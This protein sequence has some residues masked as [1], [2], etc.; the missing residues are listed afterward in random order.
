MPGRRRDS[1]D[2]DLNRRVKRYSSA[3]SQQL[4][5]GRKDVVL[6][7]TP[8]VETKTDG[9]NVQVMLTKSG[10]GTT[11]SLTRERRKVKA[12]FDETWSVHESSQVTCSCRVEL[13]LDSLQFT[14]PLASTY[15]SASSS[16]ARGIRRK[17]GE[18]QRAIRGTEPC[19]LLKS[20]ISISSSHISIQLR[21]QS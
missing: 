19:H 6:E 7:T 4:G 15:L 13:S 2:S 21:R 8:M 11:G 14:R 18:A 16:E 5:D 10:S 17:Y 12:V 20:V 9:L 3:T 1:R